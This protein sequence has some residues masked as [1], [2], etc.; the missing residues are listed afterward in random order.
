MSAEIILSFTYGLNVLPEH[1]PNVEIIKKAMSALTQAI[2]PD[3]F[4]VDAILWL[5]YVFVWVLF[6]NFKQQVKEWKQWT[7]DMV[8]IPYQVS[9][10]KILANGGITSLVSD[11][12]Q[13]IG[14]ENNSEEKEM[15]LKQVAATIYEGASDMI[16]SVVIIDIFALLCYFEVLKKMQTKINSVIKQGHISEFS[17]RES[18]PYLSA[19]VKKI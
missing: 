5:K 14:E 12:L 7:I 16:V 11:G 9:K 15:M 4:L 3:R 6:A 17:D 18:L 8:E 1:D 13:S 19:L 10:E 2:I